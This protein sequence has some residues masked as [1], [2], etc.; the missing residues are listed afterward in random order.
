M[1]DIDLRLRRPLVEALEDGRDL[2]SGLVDPV[3]E[4][5][6]AVYDVMVLARM[7]RRRGREAVPNDLAEPDVVAADAEGHEL[8][9]RGQA[10]ELRRVRAGRHALS[11]GHVAGLGAAA[12]RVVEAAHAQ[13]RRDE[14]R[15]VVIRSQAA[16]R[17]VLLD[18]DDRSGGVGVAQRDVALR[19][20]A[21]R[22][23]P[24]DDEHDQHRGERDDE[25]PTE[26]GHADPPC[27]CAQT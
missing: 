5:V 6:V 20:L 9:G 8:G 2:R 16:Q 17:I 15:V 18:G 13:R 24:G 14:V 10:V 19:G 27:A 23:H 26:P 1:D 21:R 25:C 7:A 4:L 3:A 12:A 11:T 22:R